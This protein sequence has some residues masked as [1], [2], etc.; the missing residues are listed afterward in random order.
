MDAQAYSPCLSLY[1]YSTRCTV[2]VTVYTHVY[3]TVST[4][5]GTILSRFISYVRKNYATNGSVE[6]DVLQ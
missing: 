6:N 3:T 1:G 5:H 4:Q 2:H